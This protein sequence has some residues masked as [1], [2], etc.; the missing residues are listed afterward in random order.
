[1]SNIPGARKRLLEA[2][3]LIEE[4]L[5]L[6]DREKSDFRAPRESKTLTPIQKERIRLMRKKG[7]STKKIAARFDVHP[8]RISEAV[9]E[10]KRNG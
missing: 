3:R 4:A 10:E 9:N 5:P 8:G 7:M 2:L 6:L 1:M